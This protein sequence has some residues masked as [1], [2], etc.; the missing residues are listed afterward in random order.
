MGAVENHDI[1]LCRSMIVDAPKEVVGE[2]FLRGLLEAG[3]IDP[4]RIRTG[5]DM[6]DDAV[7]S[8]RIEALQYNEKRPLAFRV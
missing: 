8:C 7:F 6:A 1:A 4:L 3:Y 5:D 2:L